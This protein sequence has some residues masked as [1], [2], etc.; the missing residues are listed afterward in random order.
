MARLKGMDAW[1]WIIGGII[2]VLVAFMLFLRIFSSL[3]S[4]THIQKS[5]ETASNMASDINRLC[6]MNVGQSQVQT[7]SLS[8]IV[9]DIY[10]SDGSLR[11][12]DLRTYGRRLCINISGD[13]SCQDLDCTL[14]M[15]RV[16]KEKKVLSL[17][18]R[19][20]GEMN[21][22]EYYVET[23]KTDCG[24][25][26]LG[27]SSS[28]GCV[29][30][31]EDTLM[32]VPI[33]YDYNGHQPVLMHNERSAV[34]ADTYPWINPDENLYALLENVAG[35]LG[36]NSILVIY[37]ENLTDP[38]TTEVSDYLSDLAGKGYDI[39]T[40]KHDSRLY[41]EDY[42]GYDQLW[43][44][45]PGICETPKRNCT[46]V[47]DWQRKELLDIADAYSNGLGIFLITDS[48][49][50]RGTYESINLEAVNMLLEVAG[51]PVRQINSCVGMCVE[52]VPV[53]ATI[54]DAEITSGIDEFMSNA[55]AV[56][57]PSCTYEGAPA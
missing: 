28:H 33:Y 15:D 6:K 52:G 16:I 17:L 50:T 22:R 45:T 29:C 8:S 46:G 34:L 51:Y 19:L 48:G 26:V 13:V 10:A 32:E 41:P 20:R 24:V 27:E 2:V 39:D 14:E 21:Y 23:V 30:G 12:S 9:E 47:A 31:S 1:M 35:H 53:D 3:T 38:D 54:E 44:V 7:I 55:M 18:D 42:S 25:S 43:L 4:E 40:Q 11:E 56:F 36:G 5:T 49:V 37:E 57:S